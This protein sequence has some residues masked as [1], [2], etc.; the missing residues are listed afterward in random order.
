MILAQTQ[1]SNTAEKRRESQ[2]QEHD[3]IDVS[4]QLQIDIRVSIRITKELTD[5]FVFMVSPHIHHQISPCT[6]NQA[7]LYIRPELTQVSLFHLDQQ[8][9]LDDHEMDDPQ[10]VDNKADQ[11]TE[12][13][14]V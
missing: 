9:N 13:V 14:D 2:E 6:C 5:A 4:A 1:T 12:R 10:H 7:N 8:S 3:I 11:L